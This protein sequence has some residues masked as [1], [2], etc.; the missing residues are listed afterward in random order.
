MSSIK[1]SKKAPISK[2]EKSSKQVKDSLFKQIRDE[3]KKVRW[4]DKNE[5]FKYSI[6]TIIFIIAFGLYFFGLDIIFAWIKEIID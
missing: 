3:M 2:K 6:A 4:P 5:M 1:S